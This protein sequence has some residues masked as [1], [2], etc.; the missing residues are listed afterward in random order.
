MRNVTRQHFRGQLRIR[1][2]IRAEVG[3][4]SSVE[5]GSLLYLIL[6]SISGRSCP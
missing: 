5:C 1:L 6:S 4:P 3:F 2:T